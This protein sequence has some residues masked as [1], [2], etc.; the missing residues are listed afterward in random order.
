MVLGHSLQIVCFVVQFDVF[1]STFSE[2]FLLR[3]YIYQY[4][5]KING[6]AAH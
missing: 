4:L 5:S 3:K 6:I 2:N 1:W